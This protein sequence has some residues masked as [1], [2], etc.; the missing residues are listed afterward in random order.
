MK[1]VK[2]YGSYN[3]KIHNSKLVIFILKSRLTKIE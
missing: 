1:M 2:K 3:N